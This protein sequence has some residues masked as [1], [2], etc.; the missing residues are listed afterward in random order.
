VRI[1]W[2]PVLFLAT[3]QGTQVVPCGG[4]FCPDGTVCGDH[5]I[6]V[7]LPGG[8]ADFSDGEPCLNEGE[9]AGVVSICFQKQC[10]DSVC[11]DGVVDPRHILFSTQ[12]PEQCDLGAANS[13]A[14]DAACRPDCL[15]RRCGDGIQDTM[16]GEQCDDGTNDPLGGDACRPGCLAPT[17]GDGVRDQVDGYYC[18]SGGP[19][20]PVTVPVADLL[21]D[22][23]LLIASVPSASELAVW[24]VEPTLTA[25]QIIPLAI[26]GAPIFGF[27]ANAHVVLV[28]SATD[29]VDELAE[30]PGG[31]G[32][33]IALGSGRAAAV[34][35]ADVNADDVQDLLIAEPD[36]IYALRGSSTGYSGPPVF[37]AAVPGATALSAGFLNDEAY[38]AAVTGGDV[39]MAP[40]ADPTS[41]LY[42]GLTDATHVL[43]HEATFGP[44]VSAELLVVGRTAGVSLYSDASGTPTSTHANGPVVSLSQ[45]PVSGRTASDLLVGI[46]GS[47]P[48]LYAENQWM[49]ATQ[50]LDSS[51]PTTAFATPGCFGD[52]F[53]ATPKGLRFF[54]GGDGPLCNP[55]TLTA[56]VTAVL[57]PAL[58]GSFVPGPSPQLAVVD[59][60]TNDL[61]VGR[62]T[63]T[64][65][66]F[67]ATSTAPL[68]PSDP[69]VEVGAMDLDGDGLSDPVAVSSAGE[70]YVFVAGS[71]TLRQAAHVTIPPGSTTI[72]PV[73]LG[74]DLDG[75]GHQDLILV[76]DGE[77][78]AYAGNGATLAATP[79]RTTRPTASPLIGAAVLRGG[80]PQ[81]VVTDG[82]RISRMVANGMI[83]T[84]PQF[85]FQDVVSITTGDFTGDG[86]DDVVAID[87]QGLY[88][89]T[90]SPDGQLEHPR[91]VTAL[92]GYVGIQLVAGQLNADDALDV[93]IMT[94]NQLF[95]EL[96]VVL[97]DGAG[98]FHRPQVYD[99][100]GRSQDGL[101][102]V[103][104][105][106]GVDGLFQWDFRYGEWYERSDQE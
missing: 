41:P 84:T 71:G 38:F 39:A 99:T 91:F 54:T 28:P 96:L 60:K 44:L 20:Y 1:A 69:I 82:Q 93:A 106:P 46:D 11:G 57:Q 74:Q 15:P 62:E 26:T 36:G 83:F 13:D 35:I 95:F 105:A 68:D 24:R 80:A 5:A 19:T 102:V 97:G 81:I 78:D 45:G 101:D 2:L 55:A 34:T 14:S 90:T 88:L 92:N 32:Q 48:L 100:V 16:A 22:K 98:G 37:F 56:P 85:L 87:V 27:D 59:G 4:A 23:H 8:C 30:T 25:P 61:I 53:V 63:L 10:V 94:K 12:Q 64:S 86:L 75:D 79:G 49:P 104:V 89:L 103:H 40:I 70:V 77:I 3:C 66:G 50:D 72:P 51:G 6:C 67:T 58:A 47:V 31:L 52:Y 18:A 17:C 42:L 7:V 29:L 21:T 9:G 76:G 65:S 33:P 73:I 43:F